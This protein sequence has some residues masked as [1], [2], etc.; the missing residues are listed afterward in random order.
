MIQRF[1]KPII[2][3]PLNAL[4]P[5]AIVAIIFNA[6]D[7]SP[8]TTLIVSAIAMIPMA[9]RKRLPLPLTPTSRL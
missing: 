3:N 5:L 9:H 8:L 4:L 2:E 6:L 1:L 7:I